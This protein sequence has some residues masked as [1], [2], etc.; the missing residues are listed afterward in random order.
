MMRC[1]QRTSPRNSRWAFTIERSCELAAL[2]GRAI[3]GLQ[4]DGPGVLFIE[5]APGGLRFKL[6][7]YLPA[8]MM[9]ANECTPEWRNLL[10]DADFNREVAACVYTQNDSCVV[11]LSLAGLKGGI[12]VLN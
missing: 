6:A 8:G 1:D 2:L 10:R 11:R 12:G 9:L 5:D 7:V 4:Q 3:R